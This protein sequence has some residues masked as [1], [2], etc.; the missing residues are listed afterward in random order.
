MKD[1]NF[2]IYKT[3][4]ENI[5][6]NAVIKDETIWLTRKSMA[7]L[8]GVQVPAINKHLKHIFEEGELNENMVVSEMEITTQHGAMQNKTQTKL[9]Q[10]LERTVTGYF[11]Y[12][13]DL[14]ENEQSF[15]MQEFSESINRFSVLKSIQNC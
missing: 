9:A 2:L 6:I 7:E 14:I 4:V 5:S 13:E 1:F 12:V 8:F 3:E 15:T 10:Y 11:D